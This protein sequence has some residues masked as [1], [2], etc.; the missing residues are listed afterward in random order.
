MHSDPLVT[1]HD[2]ADLPVTV[3]F[4]GRGG[5]LLDGDTEQVS[6]FPA[7]RASKAVPWSFEQLL[8]LD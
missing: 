8:A 2:A 5:V 1:T 6:S 3:S 4:V 7:T